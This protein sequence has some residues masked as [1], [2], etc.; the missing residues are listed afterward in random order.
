MKIV[1]IVPI[2]LFSVLLI[3]CSDPKTKSGSSDHLIMSTLWFQQSAEMTYS[4]EQAYDRASWLMLTKLDTLKEGSPAVVLDID[5]TVLDNSPYEVELIQTGSSYRSET[6]KGWTDQARAAALP[7]ALEFTRMAQDRG[8]AVYY[9][10]NRTQDE[11]I[12]TILNLNNLGFPNADSLHV[13][14]KTTTSDKSARR[15]SVQSKHEILVYVGDQLTDY[16]QRFAERGA[17]L[18]KPTVNRDKQELLHNFVLLPNPMYGE[19]ESAVY[20]NK[21]DRPD[22]EKRV[23]RLQ[24]LKK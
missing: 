1:R 10:T 20:K 8:V 4:F 19:W 2:I 6:W 11:L 18:G 7:G 16:H 3:F 14:P 17:D 13:L 15:L 5:E 22:D 21:T 12:S 23:L 24:H 9:I